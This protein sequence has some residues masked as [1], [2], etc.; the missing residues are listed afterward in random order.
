MLSMSAEPTSKKKRSCFSAFMNQKINYIDK[1]KSE[2]D[3][4]KSCLIMN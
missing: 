4:Y 3:A 2:I 1:E